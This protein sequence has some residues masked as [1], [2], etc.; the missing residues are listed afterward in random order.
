MKDEGKQ[1]EALGWDTVG[2]RVGMNKQAPWE[3]IRKQTFRE[4]SGGWL[5]A[6]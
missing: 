1:R 2:Q 3:R 4:Q 6:E 5:A